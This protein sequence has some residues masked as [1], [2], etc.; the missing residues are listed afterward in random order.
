[1]T[2]RLDFTMYIMFLVLAWPLQPGDAGKPEAKLVEIYGIIDK[3]TCLKIAKELI[4]EYKNDGV[5]GFHTECIPLG[6]I[7]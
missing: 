6:N 4:E 7:L 1:M 5:T 3:P 2:L